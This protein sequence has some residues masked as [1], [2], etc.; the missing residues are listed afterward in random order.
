[1]VPQKYSGVV[2]CHFFAGSK[3]SAVLIMDECQFY[4]YNY[5]AMIVK[6]HACINE[7]SG[8]Q[9]RKYRDYFLQAF[10]A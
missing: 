6:M 3:K 5:S 2:F 9:N 8:H 1:M 10:L 4:S 7:I